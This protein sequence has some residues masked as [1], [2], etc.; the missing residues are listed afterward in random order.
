MRTFKIICI[1][2]LILL[3]LC[4]CQRQPDIHTHTYGS[5][6]IV[7]QPTCYEAGVLERGC[8]CGHTEQTDVSALG[9]AYGEGKVIVAST[10]TDKGLTNYTCKLCGEVKKTITDKASHILHDS[11]VI[12]D[13]HHAKECSVCSK[14]TGKEEHFFYEGLCVVCGTFEKEPEITDD[15]TTFD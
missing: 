8:T 5:W 10:C 7:T 2:V 9:H 3:T 11:Y 1:V 4:S 12:T 13:E 14:L 6:S 15:N